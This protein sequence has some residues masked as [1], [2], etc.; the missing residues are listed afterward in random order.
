M[1]R[2]ARAAALAAVITIAFVPALAD[3]FIVKETVQV[4]ADGTKSTERQEMWFAKD[5]LAVKT[6]AM[7]QIVRAD[8]K[9]MFIVQHDKKLIL[10]MALPFDLAAVLPPQMAQMMMEQ[11][12]L[13]ATVTPVDETKKVGSWNARRYDT[14]VK[15]PMMSMTQTSW[16]TKDVEL[17]M[18]ALRALTEEMVV[19]LN[20]SIKT[21][22]SEFRKIEGLE[23][24][25]ETTA[26][27]MGNTIK[28][29]EKLVSIENKPAPAG[30]Y[31]PPADYKREKFSMES[32]MTLSSGS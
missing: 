8:Q 18:S 2:F 23:V 15:G 12:K 20:P 26:I 24:L 6:P 28:T 14:E 13:E 31:D 21:A 3:Q 25:K 17:D 7:T 29:T 11:M 22:L 9:L 5:K 30:I 4:A 27:V 16:A 1:T 19:A 32:L 10:E